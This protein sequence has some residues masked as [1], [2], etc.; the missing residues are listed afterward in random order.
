MFLILYD[1]FITKLER[2]AFLLDATESSDI[3]KLS[4]MVRK[5][6]KDLNFKENSYI[7]IANKVPPEYRGS[8][9]LAFLKKIPWIAVFDL[10][11]SNTE[12]D[13]LYHI[14]NETNDCARPTK[15]ELDDFK[16]PKTNE[17]ISKV[18]TTWVTRSEEMHEKNWTR[19]SKDSLYKAL[20]AFC[21]SPTG[22]VHCVFLLLSCENLQEM[23]D[24]IECSFSIIHGNDADKHMSIISEKKE[25]GAKMIKCLKDDISK[26]MKPPC[27]VFGIDFDLLRDNVNALLGS[28]EFD[29]PDATT[30]LP[31][32]NGTL[33]PVL[34][35]RIKSLTDLEVYIPQPTLSNAFEDID[36][37]KEDFYLGN[38]ISQ[39]NL[40]H[41]HAIERTLQTNLLSRID[42]YLEGLSSL[43]QELFVDTI[44]LRYE[45]GAGATTLGRQLLWKQKVKYRCA[46][47][48]KITEKTDY[49]INQLQKFLYE[50]SET[51]PLH[52]PPVFIL[53]DNLPEQQVHHLSDTL[54]RSKT[55]CLLLCTVPLD[56]SAYDIEDDFTLG[57]LDNNELDK[58]RGVLLTLN[59]ERREEAAKVL[60]RE[61]RFMWLGLELF[62]RKYAEIETRLSAHI[63]Q[64]LTKCELKDM[65][66]MIL[67]FCCLLDYYSKRRSIY[68]HPCVEGILYVHGHLMTGG[69]KQIDRIHEKFGGLLLEDVNETN[70]YWGWRPAHALV[71]EVV[72]KETELFE[73]AMKLVEEMNKG[74]TYVKKFFIED[75]VAVFLHREKI[76]ENMSDNDSDGIGDG[77]LGILEVRTKYSQ[78]ILDILANQGE[79]VKGAL[80]L[81]IT[82]NENV[83]APQ[84]KARTFQQIAR[85]FAYEIGMSAISNEDDVLKQ[86][87]KRVTSF[88][89]LPAN[90]FDIAHQAI[91]KAIELQES[92]LHHVV[93]KATF[94]R[95][96]LKH[97]YEQITRNSPDK[98]K[99]KEVM[100][101]AINTTKKSIDKYEQTLQTKKRDSYLHA[102]IGKIQTIVVLVQI[103]KRLPYF[104]QHDDGPDE[105]F[106]DYVTFQNHPDELKTLLTEEKIKYFTFLTTSAVH[107][108][109]DFLGE[110][111]VRRKLSYEK[112]E[113]KV[114][115][116]EKFRAMKLRDQFYELT[117][118]DRTKNTEQGIV[119]KEDIVNDILYKNHEWPFSSWVKL[120]PGKISK[121]YCLLK[122]GYLVETY[123]HNAMLTYAKA[124]LQ[125]GVTIEELSEIVQLWCKKCPNSEWAHLFNYMI[126]FPDPNGLLKADTVAVK[127]SVDVCRVR[128]QQSVY[129]K[130]SAEYLLGKGTGVK[131]IIPPH[132]VVMPD[133]DEPKTE[134]SRSR[135]VNLE[136][137]FWRSR[138]VYEKL[139]RL[140]G[141]KNLKKKGVLDYRGIEIPFD[142]D[143]YPHESRDELWFCL[144]FTITGPYAYDPIDK[145]TYKQIEEKFQDNN[146]RSSPKVGSRPLQAGKRRLPSVKSKTAFVNYS[147]T[148]NSN[149]KSQTSKTQLYST[150]ASPN[151]TK[152]QLGKNS[153][154]R[155]ELVS[156]RTASSS[157]D[158]QSNFDSNQTWMREQKF[159]KTV[160]SE[161]GDQ[162]T[163]H[164]KYLD[165]NKVHHGAQ[166]RGAHK[167]VEC[168]RHTSG[169]Y[170]KN[171]TFAHT[172]KD[173]PVRQTI[174]DVCTTNELKTCNN[175]EKHEKRNH[176][177]LG[178]FLTV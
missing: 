178:P 43:E 63:H 147:A 10:F 108:L 28:V 47:L 61:K 106:K 96:K 165:R 134:F 16:D 29:E 18:E 174:C 99:L 53:V 159:I 145:D 38:T 77:F 166:V 161:E 86:L 155:E 131:S 164:P 13:G 173:D 128:I 149:V 78:L 84:H 133:A 41:N 3:V 100:E 160:R 156:P 107:L 167:S 65:Y 137:E 57:K 83:T 51:S 125:H 177:D 154:P 8:N 143:R 9:T 95:I 135:D 172:W 54:S 71:G 37:A 25:F 62:G 105:S 32:L 40:F 92:Y 81:L 127:R 55:R 110:I 1:N 87:V 50:T 44:T 49:Q 72:R 101:E 22:R 153:G 111:Q 59:S 33:Q 124:A 126:N 132:H 20:S 75:I 163:F 115:E 73:T 102:M 79:C 118:L 34:N 4:T 69:T 168:V 121:I 117:Q 176:N 171:C 80:N 120:M 66:E 12:K 26:D 150:A 119:L 97:L 138:T 64:V 23:A 122:E 68:P 175:K 30:E 21:D 74:P 93:T 19:F 60:E 98:E 170:P 114:L 146:S 35:K 48:K 158:V 36:K 141:K 24:I 140:K 139:E 130:S 148:R 103:F 6:L 142:N 123:G 14:L 27:S 112:L 116:N 88:I 89:N 15:K 144:G 56:K 58:V 70:G 2:V 45:S 5:S 94:Y 76:A 7:L 90:G 11:D 46:V 31:Y 42:D 157:R 17:T 67:R 113:I 52:I 169:Y 129:R 109:N 151:Q 162:K 39:M 152:T 136:T 85:I 82:L 104:A 91:D